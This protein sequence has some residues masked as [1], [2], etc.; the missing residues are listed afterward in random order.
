ME[1]PIREGST[2][3]HDGSLARIAVDTIE[4]RV[5][6]VW[7]HRTTVTAEHRLEWTIISGYVVYQLTTVTDEC[8]TRLTSVSNS[9]YGDGKTQFHCGQAGTTL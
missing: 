6:R 2:A 3:G 1:V 5:K 8:E 7:V 4:K 9:H